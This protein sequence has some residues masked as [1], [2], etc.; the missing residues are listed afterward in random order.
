MAST[1]AGSN[2]LA[3]YH[4]KRKQ[5]KKKNN[6]QKVFQ[7]SELMGGSLV[8]GDNETKTT[9]AAKAAMLRW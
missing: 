7:V 8:S 3:C 5:Q 2:F 9:E 6:N 1:L 4:R